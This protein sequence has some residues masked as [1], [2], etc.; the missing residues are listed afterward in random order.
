MRANVFKLL[1]CLCALSGAQTTL[2]ADPDP[3][4]KFDGLSSEDVWM[5]GA[6]GWTLADG[7]LTLKASPNAAA[8]IQ[9]NPAKV[10]PSKWFGYGCEFEAKGG[11]ALDAGLAFGIK[12]EKNYW[13]FV[14]RG[15]EALLVE[16][17]DGAEIQSKKFPLAKAPGEKVTLRMELFPPSVFALSVNGEQ[18]SS[19]IL[20]LGIPTGG[21]GLVSSMPSCSFS[22]VNASG[23]AKR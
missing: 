19:E 18:L 21:L 9:T 2:R 4:F 7:K 6:G 22:Q 23:I 10:K 11:T 8:L 3:S 15:Q 17:K 5:K 20:D 16:V 14:V 13:K 12:D 1:I